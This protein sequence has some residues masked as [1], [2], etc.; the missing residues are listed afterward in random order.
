M[1][2]AVSKEVERILRDRLS[3]YLDTMGNP[4]SFKSEIRNKICVIRL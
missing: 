3:E 2:S 4:F 1:A